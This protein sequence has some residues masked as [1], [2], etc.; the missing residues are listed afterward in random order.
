MKRRLIF[1]ELHGVTD[2]FSHTDSATPA[3]SAACLREIHR[4]TQQDASYSL[5]T[6][7]QKV[8]HLQN[9]QI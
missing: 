5:C 6:A 3:P 7:P 2:L 4:H 1:T 9:I 8:R